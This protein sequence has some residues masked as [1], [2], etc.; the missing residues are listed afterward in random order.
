MHVWVGRHFIFAIF[1][2]WLV[3]LC[4][5][6]WLICYQT[7]SLTG[8]SE[9][10]EWQQRYLEISS[11]ENSRSRRPQMKF[12]LLRSLRI[13]YTRSTQVTLCSS[14]IAKWIRPLCHKRLTEMEIW[15]PMLKVEVPSLLRGSQC[16]RT[17][18][19]S[20][21]CPLNVDCSL[22]SV[23]G[24][25]FAPWSD[26]AQWSKDSIKRTSL[27]SQQFKDLYVTTSLWMDSLDPTVCTSIRKPPPFTIWALG[28]VYPVLWSRLCKL[29][30]SLAGLS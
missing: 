4:S 21:S 3:C 12:L 24:I 8:H 27:A 23:L 11:V 10:V 22:Y 29:V 19:Y 2:T 17:V 14:Y 30:S 13:A 1:D 15:G 18:C 26:Q 16:A 9:D 28:V 25:L 20:L 5:N 7:A 6:T